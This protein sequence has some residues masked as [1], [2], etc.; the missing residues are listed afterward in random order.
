MRISS[1]SPSAQWWS[2]GKSEWGVLS[3]ISYR[4]C[5]YPRFIERKR[6][7]HSHQS[8]CDC[9]EW[10]LTV[11]AGFTVSVQWNVFSAIFTSAHD[12]K[13]VIGIG[14]I[15]SCSEKVV[16]NHARSVCAIIVQHIL[17]VL[18]KRWVF[19]NAFNVITR[20]GP[21]YCDLTSASATMAS[22]MNSVSHPSQRLSDKRSSLSW[23]PFER[24]RK[25]SIRNGG[26]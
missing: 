24:Q 8:Q 18:W 13:E 5:F 4:L 2:I 17:G 22:Y 19:S 3:P 20:M 6:Q 11:N 7:C 14:S 26:N 1:G 16:I 10:P 15:N 12:T 23:T 9:T 21:A 25:R